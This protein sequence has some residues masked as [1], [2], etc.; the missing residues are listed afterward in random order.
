MARLGLVAHCGSLS[1][2]RCSGSVFLACRESRVCRGATQREIVRAVAPTP[3]S[4]QRRGA[5]SRPPPAGGRPGGCGRVG[6]G[7]PPA[8]PAGQLRGRL[9]WGPS[10]ARRSGAEDSQR[11]RENGLA[12]SLRS[13]RA[14]WFFWGKKYF[15]C[16]LVGAVDPRQRSSSDIIPIDRM[17]GWLCCRMIL[18]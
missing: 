10:Q 12:I 14:A 5:A 11:G 6:P 17:A 13:R 15:S 18:L 7:T 3:R 2:Q 8:K 9:H 16:I 4:A 1:S